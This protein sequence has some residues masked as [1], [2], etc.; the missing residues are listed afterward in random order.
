M[1]QALAN[2][3]RYD[4]SLLT[5]QDLYLFAEG[6]HYRMEKKLERTSVR[7]REKRA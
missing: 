5:A 7:S 4:A 2:L 3:P 6:N 1:A